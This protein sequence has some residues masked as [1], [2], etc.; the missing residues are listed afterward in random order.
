MRRTLLVSAS[1][2]ALLSP[3]LTAFA[4]PSTAV[5]DIFSSVINETRPKNFTM[6]ATTEDGVGKTV[7][8]VAGSME[9]GQEGKMKAMVKIDWKESM[10]WSKE[11]ID[12]RMKDG[13]AYAR[14]TSVQSSPDMQMAD[15]AAIAGTWYRLDDS[16]AMTLRSWLWPSLNADSSLLNSVTVNQDRFHDG[17]VQRISVSD[18]ASRIADAITAALPSQLALHF[19]GTPVIQAKVDTLAD[20]AFEYASLTVSSSA[21]SMRQSLGIVIQRQRNAVQVETP[22]R[23]ESTPWSSP[24]RAQLFGDGS[25]TPSSTPSISMSSSDE[26]SITATWQEVPETE[27]RIPEVH[28]T[29]PALQLTPVPSRQ[30]ASRQAKDRMLL[31][32]KLKTLE[33]TLPSYRSFT[34]IEAGAES[35]VTLAMTTAAQV[36]PADIRDADP[37]G[38]PKS[39]SQTALSKVLSKM[40]AYNPPVRYAYILKTQKQAGT[41]QLVAA[42]RSPFEQGMFD[43]N[44]NIGVAGSKTAV[45][46]DMLVYRFFT[47]ALDRDSDGTV[48]VYVPIRDEFGV[49]IGLVA[50]VW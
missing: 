1:V 32:Q 8:L 20:G 25:A 24:L 34:Y 9:G 10:S 30:N 28:V 4:A 17:F 35:L 21:G 12:L 22:K 41:F 18:N 15:L 47:N 40:M 29:I 16:D 39:V 6:T 5:A 27:T 26:M 31:K 23:S 2:L 14:V 50:L 19:T 49:S 48:S 36:R 13:A 3:S 7:I 46:G 42:A 43:F 37:V 44:K 33:S 38:Q 45:L 11:Q